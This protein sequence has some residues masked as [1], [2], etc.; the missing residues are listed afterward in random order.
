MQLANEE[1][2][3]RAREKQEALKLRL[4]EQKE[5]IASQLELKAELK[6]KADAYVPTDAHTYYYTR[7]H[8]HT[9]TYIVA[10]VPAIRCP[11]GCGAHHR[12]V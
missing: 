6:R 1:A 11:G 3:R 2:D 8:I 7:T 4:K 10:L 12:C 9:D 5:V